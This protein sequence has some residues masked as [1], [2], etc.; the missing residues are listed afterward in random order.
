[1]QTSVAVRRLK[2]K[3]NPDKQKAYKDLVD[4]EIGADVITETILALA[5]LQSKPSG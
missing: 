1:M 2:T 4:M 3:Y 5:E